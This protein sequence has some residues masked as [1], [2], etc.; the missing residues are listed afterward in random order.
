MKIALICGGPSLERGI[1]LN[2][3]RSVLNHLE[4]DGI[5]IVPIYFDHKRRP[6]HLSP[7][8]LYS[9]TPS[10]F[11]FKLRET[12]KALSQT[13]LKQL[14]KTCE[15]AFPVMHGQF[16]EDGGIQRLLERFKIPYVGADLEACKRWDKH[17]ANAFIRAHGFYAPPSAVLKIHQDDHKKIIDRFFK[18]N[19][20]QRAVV[21]PASGGSSI[22]VYSV[23]SPAEALEKVKLLFSRR[24]DTRVVLE[25]FCIGT[26]FTVIVLQNRFDMP[27]AILPTEIETDYEKNQIFDFRKKYLPTRQVRYH[28]PPR[29]SNENIERIQV[30]AEQLFKIMGMRDFARFDGWLLPD[31]KIWFSDFNPISG[32]EQNSFLFQQTSRIGFSHRDL[33]YYVVRH[34]A[35]RHG[36]KMPPKKEPSLK[37]RKPVNVLFGG[38]TSERQVSVMSGTNAWLKLRRSEKYDPKPYFLDLNGEVWQLPYALTLNHTAEEILENCKGAE[39]GEKRLRFLEEKVK[40]RLALEEGDLSEIFFI[41]QKMSLVEFVKKS[42]FVLLGLHG[43]I[44]EDGTLQKMFKKAGVK[45]NG[46]SAETSEI[47]MDKAETGKRL[48]GLEKEGIFVAPKH[49]ARAKDFK[50]FK[51]K[52]YEAYFEKLQ[53]NL[54]SKTVIVKPQDEGCS[55]GIVRLFK[56]KDLQNYMKLV[57]GNVNQIPPGTFVNQTTPIEMPLQQMDRLLF[58]QFIEV[59][60]VRVKGNRLKWRRKKGWVEV[61]VGLLQESFGEKKLHALS[62]SLTVAEGEVLSVEEKFQ[63]GT[64]VNMTPPPEKYVKPKVLARVKKSIERVGEVLG[65]EGY[66]RLDAFIH[67]DSGDLIL[68]EVNT[69]P[70]LTPSTV[71]FHQGLAEPKPMYPLELLEKIVENKGY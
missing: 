69:L 3:A 40:L 62:P 15:L 31:G 29:F 26:E 33:F 57:L 13:G 11:D 48:L 45:F 52:D 67:I 66:S 65:I 34:A 9:N 36:V 43:G 38:N 56:A 49:T 53:K 5:E 27:V 7:S 55:S 12:A 14:L 32:M 60:T 8:Q 70:A 51:T 4:G 23:N 54:Q 68:I 22:G 28:C 58:E 17:V 47:C 1:S 18:E 64:G 71:L 21:K 37:K 19:K 44:G 39:E 25:P 50:L 61:T 63:G 59:D 41:P 30:Q 2:S 24:M 20:V 6:Y 10:D 35:R 16:G 46:P 42:E